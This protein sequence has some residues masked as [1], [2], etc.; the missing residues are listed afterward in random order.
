MWRAVHLFR[1]G[2]QLPSKAMWLWHVLVK[3][4]AI[5]LPTRIRWLPSSSLLLLVT[6]IESSTYGAPYLTSPSLAL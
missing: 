2:V 4:K 1:K 5:N 3:I 6:F